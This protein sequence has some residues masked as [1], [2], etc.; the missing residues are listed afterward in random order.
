METKVEQ[1]EDQKTKSREENKAYLDNFL[2]NPGLIHLAEKILG[3]LNGESLATFRLVSKASKECIDKHLYLFIILDQALHYETA[4]KTSSIYEFYPRWRKVFEGMNQ[5]KPTD[6]S[7][8]LDTI[9]KYLKSFKN[10]SELYN[11]PLQFAVS[12]VHTAGDFLEIVLKTGYQLDKVEGKRLFN[13]ALQIMNSKVLE[14]LMDQSDDLGIDLTITDGRRRHGIFHV[15]CITKKVSLLRKVLAKADK[16]DVNTKKE[17]LYETTAFFRACEGN[18]VEGVEIILENA[19]VLNIDLN[20][21]G[22]TS[23]PSKW[24]KL[25]PF[26][27]AVRNGHVKVVQKLLEASKKNFI[28]TSSVGVTWAGCYDRR[29]L[30]IACEEGNVEMAKLLLNH[31]ESQAENEMNFVDDDGRNTLHYACLSKSLPM[32]QF[33]MTNLLSI[34]VSAKD[35]SG[36]T[37]YDYACQSGNPKIVK[38]LTEHM[39]FVN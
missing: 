27:V 1:K 12:K 24:S 4:C 38:L 25:T 39:S 13:V 10:S 9:Q 18:F 34:D 3:N 20:A 11:D 21:M 5:Q 28:A 6:I 14:I 29:S 19:Q 2:K 17:Y 7:Q 31:D 36:Q 22:R 8:F 37:P 15:A 26:G 16:I 35:N 23:M 30:S 32:V 33:L